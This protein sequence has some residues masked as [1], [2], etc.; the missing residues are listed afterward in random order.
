MSNVQNRGSRDYYIYIVLSQT[1]TKFGRAI[2]KFAGITY[3]HASIA[4]E[5]DLRYLYSFG[6]YQHAN[7]LNA[8]LVREHPERFTL[9]RYSLINVRIYRLPVTKAQFTLGKSRILQIKHDR[10]GYLYNLFSVLSYPVLRGFGTYKAYSCA[11]FVAHMIRHMGIELTPGKRDYQ[12]T[13]EEIG[14]RF[15]DNLIFEGNLLEYWQHAPSV[16]HNFF[17][18]PGYRTTIKTSLSLPVRLLYR[19]IRFR[20]RHAALI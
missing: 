1:P 4:F 15:H 17:D 12:L 9:R 5:E 6:R 7:P 3:N 2:R 16:R 18:H 10:E 19:K 13:P 11:E 14:R 8:G 20:S